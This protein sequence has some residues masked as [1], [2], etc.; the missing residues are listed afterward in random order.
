MKLWQDRA[1]EA[2]G[3]RRKLDY[4]LENLGE[5]F[6]VVGGY[7]DWGDFIYKIPVY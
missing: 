7:H 1:L 6:I 2:H 5:P 3:N 4:M